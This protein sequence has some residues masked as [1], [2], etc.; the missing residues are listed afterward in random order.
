M[1]VT[2][3]LLGLN[4]VSA[5]C[6]LQRHRQEERVQNEEFDRLRTAQDRAAVLLER[7]TARRV[8]EIDEERARENLRLMRE[9]KALRAYMDKDVYTN[10]PTAAYFMQF[11]STTR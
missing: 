7:E 1:T 4:A 11:N 8:R 6:S 3:I 10:E 5:V 2:N 9:Q